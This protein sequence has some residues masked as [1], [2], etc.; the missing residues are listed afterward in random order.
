M[1]TVDK[2]G[3]CFFVGLSDRAGRPSEDVAMAADL[4]FRHFFTS[5]QMARSDLEGAIDE[6][7]VIVQLAKQ[8]GL[9][10]IGDISPRAFQRFGASVDNL[11]PFAELG[12]SV[13][14]VD[15]GF[16]A[17]QIA[18]MVQNPFG[19]EIMI[20]ATGVSEQ[21]L[22]GLEQAGLSLAGRLAGHNYYGGK[23]AGVSLR[24][25]ERAATLLHHRGAVVQAF[26]A[27]QQ[28]ERLP[29]YQGLA[30][31]ERQRTLPVGRAAMELFVRGV[32]DMVFIGDPVSRP[33]ELRALLEVAASPH[34]RL[35]MALEADATDA[36]RMVV[37]GRHRTRGADFEVC[38]RLLPRV[39]SA[40]GSAIP[41]RAPCSRPRGAI[42]VY[43]R[44]SGEVRIAK[45][46]LPPEAKAHVL[47][48]IVAEDLPLLDLLGQ[49]AEFELLP[50]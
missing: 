10:L 6:F 25:V 50:A 44:L 24:E 8:R 13:L 34:L 49:K 4:G 37:L 5:M 14:R 42:Y 19:L 33:E 9:R 31:M 47:G 26:V 20:N 40:G 35:R 38:W 16:N 36:E 48:H 3:V 41:D 29:G 30:T 28:P 32:A 2:V 18:R 43:P 39:A 15:F 46:D 11:S 21:S 1:D 12:L 17:G 27:S 7:R 45:T 23:E 22:A